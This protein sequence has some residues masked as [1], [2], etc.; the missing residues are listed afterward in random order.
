MRFSWLVGL[1]L[2]GAFPALAVERVDITDFAS[3]EGL[4]WAGVTQGK[5]H[6]S[7][8]FYYQ[9]AS[10]ILFLGDGFDFKDESLAE[11]TERFTRQDA[12]ILKT[13]LDCPIKKDGTREGKI[14]FKKLDHTQ[15]FPFDS[16][17][18][19]TV[20]MNR[21]LCFCLNRRTSCGGIAFSKSE[22]KGL[23]FFR[24]VVRVLNKKN[25]QAVAVMTGR[26]LSVIG[27]SSISV[28]RQ[29]RVIDAI[30]KALE[31]LEKEH[32]ELKI[33]MVYGHFSVREIL[34]SGVE[35]HEIE[36]DRVRSDLDDVGAISLPVFE[37]VRFSIRAN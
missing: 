3:P 32:P 14:V 9:N 36:D 22:F 2:F 4:L 10:K 34:R 6:P 29:K 7:C 12:L 18:F 15:K 11:V 24:E 27:R 37:G 17:E 23:G 28:K 33:E 25:P 5:S 1:I 8:H 20:V 16:N 21:G 26:F 30:Q 31:E 35:L 13:S 19:D